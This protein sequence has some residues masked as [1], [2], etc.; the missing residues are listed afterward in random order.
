MT[1][2]AMQQILARID[3]LAVKL[4]ITAQYLWGVLLRQAYVTAYMDWGAAGIGLVFGIA[5]AF[6]IR[7]ALRYCCNKNNQDYGDWPDAGM[8][9][10]AVSG[11]TCVVSTII[12]FSASF[13]AITILLNP[14]FWALQQILK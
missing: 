7:H 3:A 5:G 14:P 2:E 9:W 13:E 6:S 1:N 12:C 4:G 11:M 8:V 10:L